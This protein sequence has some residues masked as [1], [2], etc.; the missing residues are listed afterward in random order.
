V[1]MLLVFIIPQQLIKTCWCCCAA[2][3]L[4]AARSTQQAITTTDDWWSYYESLGKMDWM[5]DNY[6]GKRRLVNSYAHFSTY[7]AKV[8]RRLSII[9]LNKSRPFC[10][11]FL[12]HNGLTHQQQRARNK[13]VSEEIVLYYNNFLVD[14]EKH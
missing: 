3:S 9:M 1:T 7:F 6:Q 2:S 13:Q 4:R 14:V 12:S 5:V 10:F 11:S 8:R